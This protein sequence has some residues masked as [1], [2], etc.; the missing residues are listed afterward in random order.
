MRWGGEVLRASPQR[1]NLTKGKGAQDSQI[2]GNQIP[3]GHGE[4]T[5]IGSVNDQACQGEVSGRGG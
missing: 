3:L 4:E 2:L 1:S 5:V